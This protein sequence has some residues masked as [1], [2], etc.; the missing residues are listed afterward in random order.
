MEQIDGQNFGGWMSWEM[1]DL[2]EEGWEEKQ[3]VV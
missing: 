1:G 2:V 3:K